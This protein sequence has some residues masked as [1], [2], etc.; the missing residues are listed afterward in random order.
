[1]NTIGDLQNEMDCFY[2]CKKFE[3]NHDYEK[4]NDVKLEHK[5]LLFGV[6]NFTI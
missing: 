3:H 5:V 4:F 6:I 1:M 2:Y